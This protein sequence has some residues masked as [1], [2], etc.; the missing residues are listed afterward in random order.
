MSFDTPFFLSVFLPALVLFYSI[1]PG[2]RAKNILLLLVSLLFCAFGSISG[3]VTLLLWGLVNYIFGLMLISGKKV[4]VLGVCLNL[5]FLFL[6]KYL[7]FFAAELFHVSQPVFSLAVPLGIS[8]F[9]FKCMSYLLDTAKDKENGTKDFF[10]FLLYLSFFPQITAGPITRFRDFSPQ[11]KNPRKGDLPAGLTRFIWG[12]GKK[13]LLSL[14]MSR[15]ASGTFGVTGLTADLAWLGAIAYMMEIYFDFSG[16]SDM[17]IGLG[18]IFGFHTPENFLHPYIADSIGDFW[19]R[20][21]ISLS[22]W[23]R[24]YLYIPLG[25]NRKGKLRAALNKCIV[26]TLCGFWHG[27]SW[28][29]LL[30]GLWHGLF[31]AL[32]TLVPVKKYLGKVLSHVY[33]LLVVMLGFV[34]FR[35]ESLSQGI[36]FLGAM[37]GVPGIYH[38]GLL[39]NLIGT[40]EILTL[41]LCMLFCFPVEKKV[42]LPNWVISLLSLGLLLLCILTMAAS[43]FR[44]FIYAQF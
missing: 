26:F 2:Q 41:A 13:L 25:G 34:L 6:Y 5:A 22:Q 7:N 30:W 29:Y 42:K 23:F 28:T 9:T 27:A 36:S 18:Q 1:I 43:G 24:D 8:F 20:W 14:P 3:M 33:T 16:Y 12:L 17:A 19:R 39:Q 32:E 11:L 31:S 37:F 35:A 10:S 4:K 40:K 15:I 21:H 44:P 38:P